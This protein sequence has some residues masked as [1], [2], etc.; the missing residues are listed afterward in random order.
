M[1]RA[2][3]D[4]W[5]VSGITAFTSGTPSGVTLALQDSA[6]DLTGGGDGT[7]VVVTGDPVLARER[8]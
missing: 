8:P 1:T 6:T 3:L 7:R 5:Q 4:N 2:V